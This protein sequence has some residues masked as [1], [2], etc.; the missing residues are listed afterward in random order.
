MCAV[1]K[2]AFACRERQIITLGVFYR[3]IDFGVTGR[4]KPAADSALFILGAPSD[5]D[6]PCCL[7]ND[8]GDAVAGFRE[9]QLGVFE[10]FWKEKIDGK[11]GV[12]YL[13]VIGPAVEIS[14]VP[15]AAADVSGR[16]S[17]V[18]V[19]LTA[20]K[21]L[22]S[23]LVPSLRMIRL[24][25]RDNGSRSAESRR[26]R[27]FC[28]PPHAPLRMGGC[29][30]DSRTL[31]KQSAHLNVKRPSDCIVSDCEIPGTSDIGHMDVIISGF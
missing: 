26:G 28:D 18:A 6:S 9:V 29:F 22:R 21:W 27:K 20:W 30:G 12:H 23:A 13:K 19:A 2:R 17:P 4:F 5:L 1:L 11:Q 8:A 10:V 31:V 16:A 14:G 7:V 24:F 3:I 15:P 25:F